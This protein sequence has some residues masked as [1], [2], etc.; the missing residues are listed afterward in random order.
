MHWKN[1]AVWWASVVVGVWAYGV[2]LAHAR[3]GQGLSKGQSMAAER[4]A[5]LV[6]ALSGD[7]VVAFN[8]AVAELA[9]T[10]QM[11]DVAWRATVNSVL[12]EIDAIR[13][14]RDSTA[15]W[16]F[17][18]LFSSSVV[19]GLGGGGMKAKEM[20]NILRN[21]ASTPEVFAG[22]LAALGRSGHGSKEAI[23]FLRQ[24]LADPKTPRVT[25]IR[26][27]VV[28]AKLGLKTSENDAAIVSALKQ[29]DDEDREIFVNVARMMV[30]VRPGEWVS[31]A[32]IKEM[33]ESLDED[34]TSAAVALGMLGTRARGA[35]K[36]L[37]E[38]N[39]HARDR[40]SGG[41]IAFTLALARIEPACRDAELRR[42]FKE[43]PGFFGHTIVVVYAENTFV[44]VDANLSKHIGEMVADRDARTHK[45]ALFVL[46][47]AGLGA[48]AAVPAVLRF[49]G[50]D[51]DEQRRA[52]AAR[53]LKDI[54]DYAQIGQIQ[55][56]R[57][58]QRSV[59]VRE[60]LALSITF[61]RD[62][63]PVSK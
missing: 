25:R 5:Q 61:L 31:E 42:L 32:M 38:L 26:I 57:R 44:L 36:K 55:A 4:H 22:F 34:N 21:K 15:S 10:G 19:D 63:K 28:L 47:S 17:M 16:R 3:A 40:R 51:A 62:L 52:D 20:L 7:S 53:I 30:L 45:E 58:Q 39:E 8:R 48:R 2:G 49:V 37:K 24:K 12:K 60:Q 29:R 23:A 14:K 33:T 1:V 9:A 18:F 43:I 27:R 50:G 59:P 56:A 6:R 41:Q 46:S 35:L 54:A 13:K 11:D